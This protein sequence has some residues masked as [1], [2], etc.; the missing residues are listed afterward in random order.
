[1]IEK[2]SYY[3]ETKDTL[4]QSGCGLFLEPSEIRSIS[5]HRIV[6]EGFDM[7]LRDPLDLYLEYKDDQWTMKNEELGIF[8]QNKDYKLCL[9]EAESEFAFI[10][11]EYADTPDHELTNDAL[12]LK[13][14]L[15]S[16]ISEN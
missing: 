3:K 7:K 12:K 11:G 14:L 4:Y 16:M 5:R 2:Q 1:M 9:Q 10:Y 13:S 6:L 8:S 15:I